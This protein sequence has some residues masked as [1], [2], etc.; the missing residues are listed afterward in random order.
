MLSG[1]ERLGVDHLALLLQVRGP[2]LYLVCVCAAAREGG[3]RNRHT[4]I[5]GLLRLPLC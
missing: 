1:S 5:M 2:A 4:L 3:G